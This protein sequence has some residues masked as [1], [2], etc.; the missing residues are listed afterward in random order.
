LGG[1]RDL[2]VRLGLVR[3]SAMVAHV[4]DVV[5]RDGH[6]VGFLPRP[7][8]STNRSS[9][10]PHARLTQ[11]NRSK[12]RHHALRTYPLSAPRASKEHG[13][14]NTQ[15]S[16][17]LVDRSR[18][19]AK[20]YAGSVAHL[21]RVP[22]RA[23]GEPNSLIGL[24][25]L[26]RERAAV[27][28]V[29]ESEYPSVFSKQPIPMVVAGGNHVHNGL[30]QWVRASQPGEPGSVCA[31]EEPSVPEGEHPSVCPKQPVPFI[32]AGRDQI[33]NRCR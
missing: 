32:V 9:D 2:W 29:P 12:P 24:H 14:L 20:A 5:G 22:V 31:P 18:R 7:L 15:V 13:A 4:D 30:S 8:I 17:D 28:C 16:R 11:K 23:R 1:D 21:D 25:P 6:S 3:H 10:L 19:T 27:R 33:V 26:P